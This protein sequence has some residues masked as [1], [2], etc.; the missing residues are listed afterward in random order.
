MDLRAWLS[1]D[2]NNDGAVDSSDALAI[3]YKVHNGVFCD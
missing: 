3:Q 1:A 2:V